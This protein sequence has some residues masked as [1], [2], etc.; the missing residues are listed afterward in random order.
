MTDDSTNRARQL[1]ASAS[2]GT[3]TEELL[4]GGD[5]Y[6]GEFLLYDDPPIAHLKPDEQPHVML[7]NDLK[8]VGIDSKRNT[9]TPDGSASSVFIVTDQRLLLLVGQQDGD[10]QRS[11]SLD[12]VTGGEYHTG[13]MK[14]RVVADTREQSYHLWVD[15]SYDERD[16]DA[17]VEILESAAKRRGGSSTDTAPTPGVASDGTGQPSGTADRG[18][19]ADTGAGSDERDDT[20]ADDTTGDDDP[21]AK[22]ER[23]K[24][25]HDNDVLTDEEFQAKKS[26]LLDQI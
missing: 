13:L 4:L 17:T 10:W 19:P 11:I 8:G 16:L 22:L 6:T 12:A 14:H 9:V 18:E 21:L 26:E 1:E 3:V 2:T 15:A 5:K 25:L 20:A 23:L 7:F 24:E